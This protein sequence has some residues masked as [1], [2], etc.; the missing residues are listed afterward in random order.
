MANGEDWLM[1]PVLRGLVPY[2]A[3]V[4]PGLTLEDFARM[5]DALEVEAENQYRVQQ[6]MK[7]GST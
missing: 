5:I 6:A 7:K 4:Q 1:R 3:V 2:R